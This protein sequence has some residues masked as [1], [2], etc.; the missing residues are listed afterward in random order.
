MTKYC[1]T[2]ESEFQDTVTNCPEDGEILFDAPSVKIDRHLA[3]DIYCV[4]NEIEAKLIVGILSDA[5]LPAQ[6]FRPQV[7]QLP[8]LSDKRFVLAVRTEDITLALKCISDAR[9]DGIISNSGIFFV[10]GD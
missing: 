2:C 10:N 5:G 7:S 6:L 1:P 8:S 3:V 9:S 4:D